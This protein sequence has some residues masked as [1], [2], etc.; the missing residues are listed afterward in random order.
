MSI[1]P[2]GP[3]NP[4]DPRLGWINAPVHVHDLRG[5]PTLY[6]FFNR[7]QPHA[8]AQWQGLMEKLEPHIERGLMVI[9]IHVPIVREDLDSQVIERFAR[10]AGIPYPIAIDDGR[11]RDGI[12]VAHEIAELPTFLMLDKRGTLHDSIVRPDNHDVLDEALEAWLGEDAGGRT[13]H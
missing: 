10:E 3:L 7:H 12:A 8:Q 5:H 11:R 4:L 13:L 6:I 1:E 2:Q 9:G